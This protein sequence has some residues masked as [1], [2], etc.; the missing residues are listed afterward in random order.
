MTT[1]R[2][3]VIRP[4]LLVALSTSVVGGVQYNVTDLESGE[5]TGKARAVWKT[6]RLI[7]DPEEHARASVVR[8]KARSVIASVCSGT[9]FGLLCPEALEADLDAAVLKAEALVAEFNLTARFSKV[10]LS[11]FKG[12]VA[13]TDVQAAQAIAR[14]VAGLI[15]QMNGAI[16]KM[17]PAAIRATPPTGPRR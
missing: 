5:E 4:G 3:T 11:F 12:R 9:S 15:E 14:E 1:I 2:A 10:R 13:D 8:S 16:E 17:E 6:E 7:D